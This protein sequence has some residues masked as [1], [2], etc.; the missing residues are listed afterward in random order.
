MRRLSSRSAEAARSLARTLFGDFD[1]VE[2]DESLAD[3]AWELARIFSL[4][5]Y[6]AVH[7]ASVESVGVD[8]LMLVASD[9]ALADAGRRCGYAVAVPR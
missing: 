9:G 2:I 1:L 6:D 7:L 3:R 8:E 4:R 5:G